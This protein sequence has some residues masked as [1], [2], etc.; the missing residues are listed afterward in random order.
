MGLGWGQRS[1]I[2]MI[3]DVGHKTHQ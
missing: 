3:Q 1:G 2:F